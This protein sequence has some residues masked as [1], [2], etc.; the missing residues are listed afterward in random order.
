MSL[1][2]VHPSEF[3]RQT[4]KIT[5]NL[6]GFTGHHWISHILP[7]R[8]ESSAKPAPTGVPPHPMI[9]DAK[10]FYE[11]YSTGEYNLMVLHVWT[12]DRLLQTQNLGWV[13]SISICYTWPC[14][15]E[16][17]L[18]YLT[19]D[20]R[21][22]QTETLLAQCSHSVTLSPRLGECPMQKGMKS[23]SSLIPKQTCHIQILLCGWLETQNRL[24]GT[25]LNVRL[26]HTPHRPNRVGLDVL[27]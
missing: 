26:Y 18:V 10:W 11:A 27:R 7:T 22:A 14:R 12:K 20:W 19:N 24:G 1:F 13:L 17:T 6:L 16:G 23:S 3:I 9:I 25:T 2:L 8:S 15:M 21:H 4:W 5:I